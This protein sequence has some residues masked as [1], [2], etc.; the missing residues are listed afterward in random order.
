MN[1]KRIALS[2]GMLA[3]FVIPAMGKTESAVDS[4]I[5]RVMVYHDR[6][7]VTRIARFSVNGG[8]I[9]ALFTGL[10]GII[11]DDTVRARVVTPSSAKIL[12]LEVRSI[13]QEKAADPKAVALQAKLADLMEEKARVD[14][15]L[16]LIAVEDEYLT[17][18]R[19][20]FL[21]AFAVRGK[22]DEITSARPSVQEIDAL[23]KYISTR[24]MSN[25]LSLIREQK[26]QQSV[27]ARMAVVQHELA[28]LESGAGRAT[29][30]VR[31]SI[32]A[33]QGTVTMELSYHITSVEW[34]PGYDIRVFLDE[35]RTEFAGYG[36][37][38]QS[39]G[40]DWLDAQIG[41]STAQP[42][43]RGSLPDL[44]PVYAIPPD[45][46]PQ[47]RGLVVSGKR[48]ST[49]QEANRSLLDNVA[50][51]SR[52]DALTESAAGDRRAGSLV[53]SV[54]RRADIP[55]DG[56]PHRI[57]ISR[58]SF[59]VKFEYLSIPKLSPYAFL[60]TLGV[61]A[62]PTPILR[63]D[64]NIFLGND[65][66]GSSSTANILPG[67]DF[68]LSLTVNENIRVTR[69][70]EERDERTSGFLGNQTRASYSFT[71][72]VENYTGSAI[73]MNILDQIPVSGTEDVIV[74]GIS[75]SREPQ[76]RTKQGI[77][78]WHF[79]MQ[80][81][82]TTSITFSFTVIGP[83]EKGV[84]FFRTTLPPSV[85]LQQLMESAGTV[86]RKSSVPAAQAP[87]RMEENDY[88]M[89][90]NAPSLRQKLY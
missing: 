77:V 68:E 80:P 79:P 22:G 3:A 41:F 20:S 25:S 27:A 82:E 69:T 75:F 63:G 70:L 55:S 74:E 49:Q 72:K 71:I 62:L 18:V 44:I 43:V 1:T 54:P 39:S 28:K 46:I 13:V 61:N 38:S 53:F 76:V 9:D 51:S 31:V 42:S 67:E 24:Q 10:P 50:T 64:L 4:K 45:R 87:M 26:S 88:Q 6:A 12:D 56:S 7:H 65:F 16:K 58:E 15:S 35:K 14:A 48:Y 84:A 19:K 32:D 85:Y 59:P 21:A 5:D 34:K 86:S 89:E 8:V 81:K 83:K 40:E 90:K 11:D 60:Q 37:V 52:N 36:I 57:A 33:A 66:V 2:I 29:K 78:K 23:I 30:A 47:N 17:G 73:V